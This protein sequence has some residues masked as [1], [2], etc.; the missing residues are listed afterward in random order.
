MQ[1]Y[2]SSEENYAELDHYL[3]GFRRVFL[4]CGNSFRRLALGRHLAALEVQGAVELVR[5]GGFSPN[6][7]VGEVEAGTAAFRGAGC[8]LIVVVGGGS[9][10]D[11]AKCIRHSAGRDIP[12]LAIPTTAGSG[13]EAT[14][15]AVVYRDGVKESVDCG[16]PDA[17]MLDPTTLDTLPDYQRKATMLDALCHAVESFWS[18][19]ATPGSMDFSEKA[20]GQIM[21]SYRGYLLNTPEGNAGMLRAAHTAGQAINIAR[22]TAGH[23]MCYQ[24]TK[25]YG[26]AHGHAAALCVTV[27]WPYLLTHLGQ[28][29][30]P[31]GPAGLGHILERIA[32]AMGDSN[33]QAGAERFQSILNS[34]KLEVPKL[35]EG[36]LAALAGSVNSERLKNFPVVLC[37]H[38]IQRLYREILNKGAEG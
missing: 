16:L 31:Q 19:H 2:L 13:S 28:C 20:L 12:L 23:A 22:T 10:I 6:P 26:L 3:G 32:H 35:S 38:E 15:F 11:T 1:I 4:V 27:L 17:V 7:C 9:A 24:L 18:V 34:L 30:H 29:T 14:R 8:G 36:A 5:F 21:C 37:E 33:A 25:L